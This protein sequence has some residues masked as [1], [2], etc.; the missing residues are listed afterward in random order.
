MDKKAIKIA[1]IHSSS[2]K[3]ASVLSQRPVRRDVAVTGEVTLRG[4]V[5]EIG[6]VKEKVL[7]AYRSGLRN[8]MMPA[9]NEKDLREVPAPVRERMRFMFVSTMDEVLGHL[10][11]AATPLTFADE[12]PIGDADELPPRSGPAGHPHRELT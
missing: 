1:A 3:A 8:V 6:G 10:L 9:A 11:L 12:A 4:R 2:A 5:L 7:A